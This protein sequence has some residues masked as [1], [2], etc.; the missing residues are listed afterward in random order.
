MIEDEKLG[1]RTISFPHD[2]SLGVVSIREWGSPGFAGW[3]T[4][5][6]ARGSIAIPAGKE[7]L[8]KLHWSASNSLQSLARLNPNDLQ[9][10]D[11]RDTQITDTQTIHLRRLSELHDLGLGHTAIGDATLK[12]IEGFKSLREL[13]IPGTKIT[14]AGMDSVAR[15]DTLRTLA[16]NDTAITDEGAIQLAGLTRLRKLWIKGT[17]IS[18]GAIDHLAKLTTLARIDIR[19]TRITEAGADRLAN[20]LRN[21]FLVR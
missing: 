7:A 5:G 11:A 21:C 13:Y 10:L 6:E 2:V 17:Q 1:H 20:A 16:L 12:V 8:L 18:D 3:R 4:L 19:S 14:D 9:W 15:L